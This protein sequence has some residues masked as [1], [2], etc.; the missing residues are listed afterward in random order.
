MKISYAPLTYAVRSPYNTTATTR[1][2][3]GRSPS[4][5]AIASSPRINT[6]KKTRGVGGYVITPVKKEDGTKGG[7]INTVGGNGS[8]NGNETTI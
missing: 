6:G 1:A 5:A 7:K 8:G 2:T 3:N 4:Y